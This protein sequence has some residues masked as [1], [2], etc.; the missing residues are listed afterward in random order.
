MTQRVPAP[1]LI[2][3]ELLKNGAVPN[4]PRECPAKE[5]GLYIET[6]VG[7]Q[8]FA[9]PGAEVRAPHPTLER[10]PSKMGNQASRYNIEAC[11][12]GP[13]RRGSIREPV[14]LAVEPPE[15]QQ[16]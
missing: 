3:C 16:P 6:G 10:R 7:Q 1:T 12:Q 4:L 8:S 11:S 5:V 2:G 15:E 14:P 9:R 13:V